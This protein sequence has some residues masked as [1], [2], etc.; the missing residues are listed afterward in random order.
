MTYRAQTASPH[1]VQIHLDAPA[2]SYAPGQQITGRM[3]A[4]GA[5]PDHG[6][7]LAEIQLHSVGHR[8]EQQVVAVASEVLY[9]GPWHPGATNTYPFR[10]TV[11]HTTHS[12]RG[13]LLARSPRVAAV[14]QLDSQRGAREPAQR[15]PAAWVPL[16]LA[17]DPR[18]VAVVPWRDGHLTGDMGGCSSCMTVFYAILSTAVVSALLAL[19]VGI[20]AWSMGSVDFL[21]RREVQIGVAAIVVVVG[22]VRAIKIIATEKAMGPATLDVHPSQPGGQV[23]R[24]AG[25]PPLAIEVNLEQPERVEACRVELHV[26]ESARTLEQPR[27]QVRADDRHG[28]KLQTRTEIQPLAHHVVD[29]ALDGGRF[30]GF[31]DAA[32]IAALPPS[33]DD[34]WNAVEWRLELSIALRGAPD[35]HR[36]VPLEAAPGGEPILDS[37]PSP[38]Q[39]H[40]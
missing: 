35:F 32:T 15:Q 1:P 21:M 30:V 23:F 33:F 14:T 27:L 38:I 17:S 26:R 11:P 34:G 19:I 37:T 3:V 16:S 7:L 4:T 12:Y 8:G 5:Q 36:V 13:H 24:R 18:P 28:K 29:L 10:L 2:A 9:A 22:I 40:R 31:I 25:E 20:G 6:E 39:L